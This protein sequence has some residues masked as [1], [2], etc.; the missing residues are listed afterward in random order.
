MHKASSAS[1][2][3]TPTPFPTISIWLRLWGWVWWILVGMW[4]HSWQHY[5]SPRSVTSGSSVQSTSLPPASNTVSTATPARNWLVADVLAW[6]LTLNLSKEYVNIFI[7]VLNSLL[8][9]DS[10]LAG[11]ARLSL[12]FDFQL[13]TFDF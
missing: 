3:D 4:I 5:L 13:S 9:L 8:V 6:L 1:L 2:T 7:F 12:S 10:F 11:P